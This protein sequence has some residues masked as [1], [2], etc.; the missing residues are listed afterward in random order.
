[1]DTQLNFTINTTPTVV[2]PAATE[3]ADARLRAIKLNSEGKAEVASV[4]GET[5]MGLGI[6]LAGDALGKVEAGGGVDIQIKEIGLA[7]A[8]AAVTAGTPL[9][10]DAN[11]KLVAAAAGNFVI[12]YA[13]TSASQADDIIQVQIVKGYYPSGT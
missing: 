13:I 10:T 7:L 11:G 2:Y 4:A 9:T 5:F 3:I 12:G 1:M 6:H 8:G